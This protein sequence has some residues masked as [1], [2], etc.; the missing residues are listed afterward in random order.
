MC[1][2]H[3]AHAPTAPPST[4]SWSA[5]A[6]PGSRRP[7]RAER[8]GARVG[9]AT[10]TTLQ[11]CNSAKAQGGIQA[12]FGED[13]S[14]EI[15]A[16]DV[17]RS[18]HD[19]ADPQ[20]VEVL[21]SEAPSAIHWLEELGV[22]FTRSN[23]G[24][25]LAR[26]GGATQAAAAPGR[27]PNRATRS[28]RRCARR[29]RRA[30][31]TELPHHALR[32]ARAVRRAAGSRSFDTKDGARRDRGRRRRA[33]GRRALL[34]GGRDARRALHEPPERDRRGDA[35]RAGRRRRDARPRRAPVPPERRRLA[36]DDAGLLDPGDDARLRRRAAAT[37]TARSSRT[38]S[39]RA[40]RCP[41][42]IVAE[43][44]KGKGVADARRAAG[45]LARH[46]AHRA[47]G[48][49][50]LAAV[51]ASPLSRRRHRPA[52]RADLHVPRP[53]LP[54]RWARDRRARG[55]DARG[56]LRLRR[57]RGR[58]PRKEPHDG[59]LAARVHR[60]RAPRRDARRPRG[61][62]RERR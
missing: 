46:D 26:C 17:M 45:R 51:H 5:A 36:V 38:R 4:C 10:K 29:T 34:R 3:P 21:T 44:E 33:R 42:A 14:P 8:A 27:R 49:R 59:Q 48:R 57:D 11:A 18:S 54:E 9:L 40:T 53:P 55:D 25:R 22:E 19:T 39:A 31:A 20:L 50:D 6:L 7:C 61:R 37:P 28:R 15:H 23:G 13:D 43:V 32:R 2:T 16:E 56:R 58:H 52:R 62:W 35:D 12:A 41:Q 1:A 60:L 24:Y 47:R 30:P